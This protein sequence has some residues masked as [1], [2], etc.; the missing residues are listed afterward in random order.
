LLPT[1]LAYAFSLLERRRF[2]A[3]RRCL[4]PAVEEQR[5]QDKALTSIEKGE[6]AMRVIRGSAFY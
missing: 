2:R 4:V 3:G 1:T 6:A 5:E